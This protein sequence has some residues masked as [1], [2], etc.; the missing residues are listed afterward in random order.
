MKEFAVFYLGAFIGCFGSMM[1]AYLAFGQPVSI[2]RLIVIPILGAVF[3]WPIFNLLKNRI[4][5]GAR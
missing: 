3:G 2:V 5:G 4:L 1:I